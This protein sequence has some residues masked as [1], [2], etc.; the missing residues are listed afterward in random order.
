[1]TSIYS[2]ILASICILLSRLSKWYQIFLHVC[3]P[4]CHSS[5]SF[6]YLITHSCFS[7]L[8]SKS[9]LIQTYV[10][11]VCDCVQTGHKLSLNKQQ[12][13][14]QLFIHGQSTGKLLVLLQFKERLTDIILLIPK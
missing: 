11:K 14:A 7:R 3:G 6:L 13:L 9:L 1:M 4:E 10:L 8:F 2:H 12:T 5:L